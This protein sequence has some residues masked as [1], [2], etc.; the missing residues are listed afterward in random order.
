MLLAQSIHC[1]FFPL[2]PDWYMV[3]Q[4]RKIAYAK[5]DIPYLLISVFFCRLKVHT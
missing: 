4:L 5:V 2:A 1:F 3:K